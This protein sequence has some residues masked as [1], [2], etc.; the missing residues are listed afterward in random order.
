MIASD[1]NELK[2]QRGEER[3]GNA[4]FPD[5]AYIYRLTDEYRWVIPVNHAP[6]IFIGSATLPMNICH[7]YSSVM[8]LHR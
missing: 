7:V 2:W 5:P 4:R 6:H 8:W 3:K 1:S